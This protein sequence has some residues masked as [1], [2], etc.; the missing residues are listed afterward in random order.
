MTS[1]FRYQIRIE[2]LKTRKKNFLLTLR[3]SRY[4]F[5]ALVFH[6]NKRNLQ[7]DTALGIPAHY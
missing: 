7:K 5:A 4:R 6:V 2:S 1:I 3:Y